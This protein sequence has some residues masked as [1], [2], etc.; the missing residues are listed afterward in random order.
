MIRVCRVPPVFRVSRVC[1]VTL[2]C[3]VS[4][5]FRVSRVC[6]VS[7]VFR[8]TPVFR[9]SRVFR[10]RVGVEYRPW[11]AWRQSRPPPRWVRGQVESQG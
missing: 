11:G 5:V 2:V 7:W 3:R 9:V 4:P 10:V 1:R 8:V 6:R